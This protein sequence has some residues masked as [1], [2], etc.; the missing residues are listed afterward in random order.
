MKEDILNELSNVRQTEIK[1]RETLWR[2]QNN[3]K[4]KRMTNLGKDAFESIMRE[5]TVGMNEYNELFYTAAKVVAE[6]YFPKK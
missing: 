2:I 5:T 4:N 3:K 1:E 6:L